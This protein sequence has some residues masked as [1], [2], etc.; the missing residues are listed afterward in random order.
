MA[1]P[2]FG[3]QM[4]LEN[5]AGFQKGL[6]AANKQIKAA[7]ENLKDAAKN[8]NPLSGGLDKL[9]VSVD[10]LKA[11]FSQLTGISGN[12]LNGIFDITAALGP[13]G[14]ALGAAVV[15]V[16]ALAAGFLALGNRGAPLVGLAESFDR[17]SASVGISSQTLLKDLREASA[18]T[19]ADFDL[20]KRANTALVGATGEFGK[21]FGQN[22]PKLLEAAR[23]A[24]RATGQDVDFLFQSLVT[25]IKRAS[26]LLIDNTGIVLK[27]GEANEKLAKSLGKSVSE[28][29]AEEKQIAVLNATV[30]SG[31]RLIDSLGDSMETNSEKLA[32][33]QATI[34]NIFDTLAVAMQP[35][36][37]TVLD[38][39][40][41]VLGMFQQLAVGIAPILGSIASIITDVLGGIFSVVLDIVQPVIDAIAS[42]L[43][44]I[45]ILFQGIANII[46]GVVTTI[47]NV[48]NGIVNFVKSVAQNLFGLDISNL[49]KSLFEGAAAAFGSFA[50]GIIM[51]ANQLIFPAVIAIAKFVADFLIG[52][53]PPKKGPLSMIDKGGENVMKAWL[54]G[55]TGVSLDPVE[56]VAAE[57]SAALG[58]IGK[59]S[60]S[61]VDA[62]LRQLDA[63]LLPFQNRLAIVKSQFEAL[64]APAQAALDAID[65]QQQQA[66]EAL[67]NG[68]QQAAETIRQLDAARAAIQ[69]QLDAQQAI[70][71]KQ[72][73]QLGLATASQAQERALLNIRKAQ[74]AAVQ[75]TATAAA[76][77]GAG[78][79]PAEKTG[80]AGSPT[81]PESTGMGAGIALPETSALDLIGGQSAVN[82]AMAGIQDAFIGQI[83][84]EQLGL[85]GENSAALQEQF[86]RI[87]SVDLGAKLGDKF[88]GL[89]DL[90]DANVEGSPANLISKFFSPDPATPGSL[91]SFVN[92]LPDSV[93]AIAKDVGTR[94]G[95]SL[96]D[97][98]V[99]FTGDGEGTLKGILA[100]VTGDASVEGSVANF[101]SL[102]PQRVSDAAS[103]LF[104]QL[105]TD[106]FD[107]VS[108]FLTGDGP[109]TLQ[110]ILNG[111]VV[112][113]E[114]LP[115]QI[116][117]ALQGIGATMY[118]AFALPIISVINSV[119]EA[120]ENT[121]K[122]FLTGVANFLLGIADGLGGVIDTSGIRNT[123]NDINTKA[124]SVNFGRLSTAIP[125]FLVAAP[126][127][128][129]GGLFGPG[130]I[131][132]GERGKE[133]IVAASQLAIFPAELTRVLDNLGT[134]LAQ[135]MPMSAP[136]GD[137]NY[138]SSS[139]VYNFNGVASDQ[140]A[141]RRFNSLRAGMR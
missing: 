16:A 1:L 92:S 130:A 15:G 39:V 44:Y 87:G 34:T 115:G 49:G 4:V 124:G 139:S 98:F 54:D 141:R 42:F 126:A 129:K 121:V 33:S 48:V 40:N 137:T 67:A 28:L 81:A 79:T 108:E 41:R 6:D 20:I 80:G 32:R 8:A 21:Q 133:R 135:P 25:G 106:V 93:N 72:Q 43:P 136:G 3:L 88:K 10:G 65:R 103:G 62:R 53:S 113:F 57:V 128:A 90:F 101:F 55:I 91:S 66:M 110:G 138:N 96:A 132:V 107:P 5:S 70:V 14:V 7:Q 38:L 102:L 117:M 97:I 86:D 116:V 99:F 78:K 95:T 63:A 2:K 45:S 89:T 17:L 22:L 83:D 74:L 71:D 46:H 50:N 37:G 29:T 19:V 134:V 60:L 24:S 12:A 30:E 77:I 13:M 31:Q 109:D 122:T 105:K 120:A 9:G 84:T 114:M 11:K 51:V 119:L 23:A 94:L 118:A 76:Q 69:G 35:A 100:I 64:Q 85:F 75:K 47:G 140:D 59:A 61:V 131:D 123:A 127:A 111:A 68:D 36:F 73:I 104:D 56:Q 26:P 112:F 27:V 52:F 58:D 125:A 82:E 18:G